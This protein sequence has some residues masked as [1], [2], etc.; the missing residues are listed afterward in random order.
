MTAVRVG[1]VG[2]G[3]RMGTA[4]CEAVAADPDLQLVAAV[5]PF[6]AGQTREGITVAGEPRALVDAACDVV[7]D[8]TVAVAA[9]TTLPFLAMHGIHAVVGTTGF[10]DDDLALFRTEF[11]GSNCL[12]ASNFAISAVLMMR[13]AELAAPYFDTAEIIEL[14]HDAKIDAPSGTAVTTAQRMAVASSAWAKDP[15][16]HEVY[17]GARGGEG[18]AGIRVHSVRMRG[19]VAHQEVILGAQGQTLT[20]RQDSYDRASYM[21]GVVLACKRIADHPGLTMGLDAFLGI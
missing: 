11:S 15:T 7:V 19:M 9:R 14:H 21:P 12:I 18:P 10:T 16:Q 20:I 1:V 2:A 3:G 17:P 4:V 5:D 6:A 8:F 13:F